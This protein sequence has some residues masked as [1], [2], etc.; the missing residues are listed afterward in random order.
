MS[1]RSNILLWLP[2][3]AL[4]A[5]G[6]DSIPPLPKDAFKV[7]LPP[8]SPVELL[9]PNWDLS[10]VA[11]R[12]GAMQVD[13]RSTLQLRNTSMRR[14]RGIS[15]L[16]LAQEVTPGG[17]AS[18]TVPSLD[19]EP[20][21]TFPVKIDLRLMRPISAAQGPLVEVTLDGVLFEDLTFFGPNKLN[22]RRAMT[23]WELE[24]R[25]D[26]KYLFALLETGGPKTLQDE[27]V[28]TLSR[29]TAQPRLEIQSARTGPSTN[30]VGGEQ[31]I[32]FAFL[33]LPDAPVELTGGFVRVAGNQARL[34]RIYVANRSRRSV[35][36]LEIGWLLKD[37]AG[38][39]YHAGDL[40]AVLT[41]APGGRG[42]CDPDAVLKFSRPGGQPVPIAGLTAYVANVEFADG[43]QWIPTHAALAQQRLAS[44][45]PVS[46]ELQRLAELYRKRGVDAVAQQLKRL[47]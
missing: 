32:E 41:L 45:L 46:P 25:R 29:V 8:G 9:N 37:N 17:K 5:F 35:R 13:L 42:E 36:S 1:S 30:S 18:V 10:S 3:L 15:F 43:D 11:M 21:D 20:G 39:E 34:P 16:V 31:Q 19:V 14:I 4:L 2:A 33:A 26:R 47:K 38:H 24:A 6:S 12:G 22:S 28:A 44:A 40:P 7:T 23:G 27:M